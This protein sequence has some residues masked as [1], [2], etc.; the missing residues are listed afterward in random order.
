MR[1]KVALR[2]E[3]TD[4]VAIATQAVETVQPVIDAHRHE[5]VVALS[6]EP[7]PVD[8]DPMRLVQVIANL[9]TNA[10]KYTERGGR[11]WLTVEEVNGTGTAR[12]RDTGIGIDPVLLPRVFDLFVQADTAT[13][14]SQGGLGIGLT[15]VKSLVEMHGGAVEARSDGPGRG[16]EFIVRLPLKG[17]SVTSGS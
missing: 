14:R 1:G 5:L 6:P 7:V 16:S 9:L 11:I 8:A 13:D 10:A 15:L 2:C 3:S 4:L 12:V 17:R